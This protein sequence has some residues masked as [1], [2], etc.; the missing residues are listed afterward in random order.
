MMHTARGGLRA[1]PAIFGIFRWVGKIGKLGGKK[2]SIFAAGMWERSFLPHPSRKLKCRD[3]G[4]DVVRSDWGLSDKNGVTEAP[5]FAGRAK[6]HISQ[7]R[8][9]DKILPISIIHHFNQSLLFITVIILTLYFSSLFNGRACVQICAQPIPDKD[10]ITPKN[11]I[12]FA[13]VDLGWL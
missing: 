11:H 10:T 4:R 6:Q 5:K 2:S 3:V 1:L 12:I 7:R 9:L 8:F 13:V